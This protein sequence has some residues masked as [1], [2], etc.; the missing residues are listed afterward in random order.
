MMI[1]EVLIRLSDYWDNYSVFDWQ[2][3][4]PWT[5]KYTKQAIGRMKM[6]SRNVRANKSWLGMGASLLLARYGAC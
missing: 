6:R 4:V 2:P 1:I 5:N 3:D